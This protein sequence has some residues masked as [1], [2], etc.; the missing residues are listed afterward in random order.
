MEPKCE[1]CKMFF[2][3][4]HYDMCDK[5]GGVMP[6]HWARSERG[7]CGPTGKLFEPK[8]EER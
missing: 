7:D 8:E 4:E 1:E 2:L 6:A 3:G 5:N